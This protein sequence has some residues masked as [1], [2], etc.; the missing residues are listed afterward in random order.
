MIR[1][2]RNV[3]SFDAGSKERT[4]TLVHMFQTLVHSAQPG[5]RVEKRQWQNTKIVLTYNKLPVEIFEK[6]SSGLR[7]VMEYHIGADAEKIDIE[8]DDTLIPCCPHC[9]IN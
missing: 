9:K 5:Q 4:A 8:E 3:I 2:Y 6:I 7:V 1:Y